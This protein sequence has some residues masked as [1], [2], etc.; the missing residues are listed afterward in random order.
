MGK[1][2]QLINK[3]KNASLK[4]QKSRILKIL[5]L[6]GILLSRGQLN[7]DLSAEEPHTQ[8]IENI[9]P[10]PEI[11][12][13]C[14]NEDKEIAQNLKNLLLDI[15]D[16][17]EISKSLIKTLEENNITF[18]ITDENDSYSGSYIIGENKIIIPKNT[19][20]NTLQN[21]TETINSFKRTITH[22]TI[23]MLQDKKGIFNDAK[24]MSPLDCSIIYTMAELDAICKSYIA[25][26]NSWNTNSAFECF[27][28]ITSC[29][30]IY[31]K[32]GAYIGKSNTY[33][34]NLSLDDVIKKFNQA[35]FDDYTNIT[36][37]INTIK[38]KIRPEIMAEIQVM[39][40]EYLEK[41]K[42]KNIIIA[43]NFEKE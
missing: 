5:V 11:N 25:T 37:I 9:I 24:Q 34:K 28:N 27:K 1:N 26:D 31:S 43:K 32:Q 4:L 40:K 33:N 8:P 41:E 2:T 18:E 35:G 15:E 39:N 10:N 16:D 12:I 7:S 21:D 38:E 13:V 23:H 30:D 42:T 6:S 29:L 19:I 3:F 14:E 17:N 22:E 36:E 20:T